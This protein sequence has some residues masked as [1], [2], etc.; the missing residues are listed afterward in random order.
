MKSDLCC[1]VEATI[2]ALFRARDFFN[3]SKCSFLLICS[4]YCLIGLCM[5]SMIYSSFLRPALS[6]S[7]SAAPFFVPRT[8]FRCLLLPALLDSD[9]C[10]LFTICSYNFAISLCDFSR[11]CAELWNLSESM[12]ASSSSS[13]PCFC[14]LFFEPYL[15]ACCRDLI[16]YI[17]DYLILV[18]IS[19][20][21]SASCLSITL[22]FFVKSSSS[23]VHSSFSLELESSNDLMMVIKFWACI[24]STFDLLSISCSLTR[25]WSLES[26]PRSNLVSS[27]M[28][29]PLGPSKSRTT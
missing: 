23:P 29:E 20:D 24:C 18:A 7:F 21:R 22:K 9:G 12:A 11:A 2:G 15:S 26:V 17:F 6:F 8:N 1:S 13:F 28:T 16:N 25:K 5:V 4:L 19:V 14:D 3:K 10:G 27:F